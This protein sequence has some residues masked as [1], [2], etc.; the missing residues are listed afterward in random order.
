MNSVSMFLVLRL[1][2]WPRAVVIGGFRRVFSSE[3]LLILGLSTGLK[4][5]SMWSAGAERDSQF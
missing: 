2:V 1:C 3:E 4:D 5:C